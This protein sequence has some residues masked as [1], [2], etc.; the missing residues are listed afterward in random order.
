MYNPKFIVSRRKIPLVYNSL[1]NVLI[2]KFLIISVNYWY[3]ME[4]DIKY[5]Y[6]KLLEGIAGMIT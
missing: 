4:F 5:N 1:L 6:Y 3:D 2:M